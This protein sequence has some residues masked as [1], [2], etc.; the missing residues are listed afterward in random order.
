MSNR[1][2]AISVAVPACRRS[3]ELRS[4]LERLHACHPA[5]AEILVHLDG[6]DNSL[7]SLVETEFPS[8][9]VLHSDS[10]IGPGGARNKM[11][12]EA[13]YDWVAHFD[14][15]S[16][17]HDVDYFA[18]A[19]SLIT[20]FPDL[21]VFCASILPFENLNESDFWLQA[22]YPG[23][24]HLMNRAWF[25][26]TKGY[27]RLPV[28]Y[29]LEEV[30]VSIQLCDLGGRCLQ[31]GMLRVFH[32]HP[33]APREDEQTQAAIMINT[34]IFPLLRFPLLLLPQAFGSVFRRMFRL[35]LLGE[36]MVLKTTFIELPSALRH[37]LPMR[38]PVRFSAAFSWLLLRHRPVRI[39]PVSSTMKYEY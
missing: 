19:W 34:I 3:A 10:L 23:C 6:N 8:V 5:P 37:Y 17:P 12:Q 25:Q 35:A 30:D 11:M 1:I 14:D 33:P 7:R 28:A 13:R 32:D 31:S 16:F 39:R 22:Y 36:W 20:R 2:V 4:T 38:F 21:A 24:G 18:R 29:N 9:R 26:K 15:D 27:L